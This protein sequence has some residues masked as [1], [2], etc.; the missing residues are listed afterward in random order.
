[1]SLALVFPWLHHPSAGY[2]P[3]LHLGQYPGAN[4]NG[5]I[6]IALFSNEESKHVMHCASP[7]LFLS[8]FPLLQL[9]P[10]KCSIQ[11]L[12]I[13]IF[14]AIFITISNWEFSSL[15]SSP[16]SC[17]LYHAKVS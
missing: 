10:V 9:L 15:P 13:T 17:S 3:C 14:A 7:F 12:L 4:W 2:P 1:M 11:T 5:D 16:K 8:T 6:I